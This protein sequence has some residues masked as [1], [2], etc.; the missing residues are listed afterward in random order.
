MKHE[1]ASRKLNK[2]R[3]RRFEHTDSCIGNAVCMDYGAIE[4]CIIK[5][6]KIVN[7]V[8]R[9]ASYHEVLSC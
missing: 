9:V 7:D 1:T 3:Y 4:L 2:T 6:A 5:Q 8:D